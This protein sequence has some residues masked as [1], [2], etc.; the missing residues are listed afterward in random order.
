MS[1]LRELQRKLQRKLD[2]LDDIARK[3]ANIQ[4]AV[5]VERDIYG[6]EGLDNTQGLWYEELCDAIDALN[7]LI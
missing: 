4:L 1:N 7:E 5:E 6:L 2:E 3:W